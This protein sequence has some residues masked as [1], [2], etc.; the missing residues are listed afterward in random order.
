MSIKDNPQKTDELR[1]EVRK[2]L[3]DTIYDVTGLGSD[4][5]AGE[6]KFVK[7][8]A[9][10]V[11]EARIDEIRHLHDFYDKNPDYSGNYITERVKHLQSNNTKGKE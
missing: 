3:H 10:K 6:M 1:L 11:N 9:D 8:I 7:L 4:T 5:T 2:L